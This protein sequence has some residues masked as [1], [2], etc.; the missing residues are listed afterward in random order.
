MIEQ[1]QDF[2][3][4]LAKTKG[5]RNKVQRNMYYAVFLAKSTCYTLR[6]RKCSDNQKGRF[7][8]CRFSLVRCH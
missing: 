5:L 2:F 1:K 6:G 3:K 8:S 4:P 7:F